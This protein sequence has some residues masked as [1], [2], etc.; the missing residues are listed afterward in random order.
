ME[1]KKEEVVRK[2]VTIPNPVGAELKLRALMQNQWQTLLLHHNCATFAQ[3]VIK[4]G[5]AS[6]A[7]F[8]GCPVFGVFFKKLRENFAQ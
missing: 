5:G 1:G 2:F 7:M 4:A 8:E 6:W 3:E